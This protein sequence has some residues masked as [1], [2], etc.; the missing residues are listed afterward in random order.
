MITVQLYH[1]GAIV[2]MVL[3]VDINFYVCMISV[4]LVVSGI[5]AGLT[6]ISQLF[7]VSAHLLL[8][9][10]PTHEPTATWCFI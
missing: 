2:R 6:I 1:L 5:A 3:L 7:S 4:T 8:R 10:Q 9:H